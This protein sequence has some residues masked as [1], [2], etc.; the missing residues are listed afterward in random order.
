MRESIERTT[1]ANSSPSDATDVYLS[2]VA[3]AHN[4]A[5][6]LGQFIREVVSVASTLDRTWEVIIANDA[7]TDGTAEVLRE[8]MPEVPSLRVLCLTRRSGQTAAIDAGLKAARGRFVVTMDADLQ[9]DPADIPAMLHLVSTGHCDMVNGWRRNRQDPWI[10]LVSTRVANSVRNKLTQ[11]CIRDSACGLKVFRREC[12]SGLKLFNG[13]HRFLPTLVKM[14]GF[15]VVEIPV[16]H[17]PR[18][19]GRAKYGVANRVFKALRD[20]LAVR[21]M[22]SRVLR[23]ECVEWER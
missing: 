19:A 2:I 3:P 10:R 17:R 14:E 16:N 18:V 12:L 21:W 23:Y 13:M 15:R 11:E 7:S 9:N 6:N 20:A 5:E 22:Q 4:E 1:H 8:L